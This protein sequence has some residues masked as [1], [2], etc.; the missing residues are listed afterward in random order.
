[1]NRAA[2]AAALLL[3]PLCC[4]A[5]QITLTPENYRAMALRNN[6]S[7][8]QAR[9]E[10]DAA[11][12]AAKAAFTNYFPKLSAGGM[13]ANTNILPGSALSMAMLPAAADAENTMSQAYVM[14][15][16]PLFAGGRVVNGNRLARAGRDAAREQLRLKEQETLREA[17]KKYRALLVIEAKK[18]T[19]AAYAAMLDALSAQ[20]EQ[21]YAGGLVTRTDLLRVNLKKAEVAVNRE[22]LERTGALA[23]RDLRIFGGIPDAEVISLPEDSAP[24]AEPGVK[25]EE[26]AAALAQRPEYRLLETGARAARLRTAMKRGEYLPSVAAGA[27][28]FRMDYYRGGDQRYQNSAAFGV[29][30]VPLDLWGGAHA[31]KEQRLIET[32]AEERLKE[33]GQYLLLDL[34]SRLKDYDAAWRTVK[35]RQL[36]VEEASANSS[37]KK[38]G[39]DNGTE[40]LSDLLE[41]LAL[42]QQ[43]RDAL[44]EARAGYF[45]ARAGL[46]LAMGLKDADGYGDGPDD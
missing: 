42:E 15:Q 21:A 30:S 44:A 40:K 32:A 33:S 46:R 26:L 43:S 4:S 3:S 5:A 10:A 12:Q 27:A 31:V 17:E 19:L 18:K 24:V 45:D 20:V 36:A 41:A 22:T 25:R 28:L 23:E 2:F 34:E 29:V 35:L 9:L 1:M 39:F 38:D 16:L 7:L 37:E 13:A 11:G 14:A 6:S 8:R